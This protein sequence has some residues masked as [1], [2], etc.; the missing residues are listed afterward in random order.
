MIPLRDNI[1]SKTK[2]IINWLFILANAYFFYLELQLKDS[3]ALEKFILYWGVVPSRLWADLAHQGF[4]LITATF[5]HGGWMHIIGN[6]LFLH[7]FGDNVE[8]RMGHGR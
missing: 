7:I 8:D 2:P 1:T 3:S 5:L 4:T 6:M